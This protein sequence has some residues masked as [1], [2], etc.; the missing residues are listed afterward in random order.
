MISDVKLKPIVVI[1]FECSTHGIIKHTVED[2]TTSNSSTEKV[3]LLNNDCSSLK[4]AVDLDI[5]T[6]GK[7]GGV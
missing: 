5:L 2:P 4:A 1:G 7:I 3:Q 6:S